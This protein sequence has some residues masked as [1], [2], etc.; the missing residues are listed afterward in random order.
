MIKR[1][2]F[3]LKK[4]S[5]AEGWENLIYAIWLTMFESIFMIFFAEL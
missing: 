4:E 3:Y 5:Q 2:K 1:P